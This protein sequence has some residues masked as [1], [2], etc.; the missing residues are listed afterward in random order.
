M[1]LPYGRNFDWTEERIDLVRRL[2]LEGLSASQIA[3][4]LRPPG[5]ELS[6]N[7]VIGKLGRLGLTKKDRPTRTKPFQRPRV[8]R[9]KPFRA[10]PLQSPQAPKPAPAP[11]PAPSAAHQ[12]DILGLTNESC[13]WVVS[14]ESEPFMFCGMPEA[15]MTAGVSYCP[16]HARMAYRRSVEVP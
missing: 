9:R 11:A 8:A 5:K 7:A 3:A 13:R 4:E 2:W 15:D 12:C 1:S 6:R 14:G 10:P 16:Y